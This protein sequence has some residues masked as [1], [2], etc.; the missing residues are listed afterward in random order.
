M[1]AAG[2][3]DKVEKHPH[4]VPHG[5]RSG[6]PL[7]PFLTDQWYCDAETLAKPA[8]EAVETGRTEFVPKQ[9]ENTYFE[10]M[11][12]IQPWCIS[13]QLWW[14]HQIPAWYGPDGVI[15]VEESEGEARAAAAAHYGKETALMRDP[16][17]LDTWFSSGLW[18]FS[19]LGW[20]KETPELG[21]FYPTSV[22][23]T[24][25]DIIFFWVA[26]M[27]MQG[28][29]FMG[30][31]PFHQVL[32]HGLVRDE[33]GHK[34][35]KTRGNVIDP[36]ELIDEYGADA[37]RYALMASA[38]QGRDVKIGKARIESYRNFITKLWNACRFVEMNGGRLD[39]AFDPSGAGTALNRWIIGA[40]VRLEKE[41]TAAL[42]SMK[43]NEA[44]LAIYHFVWDDFC[45]WYVELSKPALS[46]E[47]EAVAVETRTTAAWV[48]GQVLHL[49]H[50][51]APFVS[52][53]LWQE[54]LGGEGML[55][56]AD[57][58][59]LAADLADSGADAEMG[60]LIQAIGAIRAARSELNVPAG[61]RLD[62]LVF[63]AGEET[64]QRIHRHR[65]AM[66]R[67]A[68]LEKVGPGSG[69]IPSSTLQ[70]VVGEAT[71]AMPVADV[72]DLAKERGRLEK[73]RGKIEGEMSKIEKKLANENFT[74]RAPEAVVE[75]QRDRLEAAR[76]A[77]G[78]LVAAI[79]R[80]TT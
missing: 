4:T 23:V 70:V 25:F 48:I 7:E 12:N 8:I 66:L 29:H 54:L 13:R 77:H 44:A 28:L 49:M 33:K 71:F 46:G 47:D 35:S 19:T 42:E 78:K 20:P 41:V 75:E 53:H 62:V 63:G 38:A 67:L 79:A 45:D 10:W 36:L 14:G 61:A 37:L 60:W 57:W 76:L 16:D 32:I 58:P 17:V 80:I 68:R 22:L 39:P 21:Q 34:M 3:L 27:M 55:I 11:R 2:L 1:E 73:E 65:D 56:T 74:S 31:V 18:P 50:P 6:V 52:E 30:E 64:L 9:W 15:F 24:G 69:G 26:R 40:T 51:I 5:D 59:S 43:T 72:V